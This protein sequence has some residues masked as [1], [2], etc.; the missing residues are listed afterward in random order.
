MRK[1]DTEIVSM[2]GN[3]A[4]AMVK[5]WH[6]AVH[7]PHGWSNR[8]P[9]RNEN[10][11]S[12]RCLIRVISLAT[13]SQFALVP[14]AKRIFH[15]ITKQQS[16]RDIINHNH[17]LEPVLERFDLR[18]SSSQDGLDRSSHG[19]GQDLDFLIDMLKVFDAEDTFDVSILQAYP[20]PVIL[21]YLYRTHDFYRQQRLGEIEQSIEALL[22]HCAQEKPLL[23]LLR[24]AFEQYERYLLAHMNEEEAVLFPYLSYLH[25]AYTYGRYY[26]SRAFPQAPECDLV[27]FDHDH[28]TQDPARTFDVL[29][30]TIIRDHPETKSMMAFQILQTQL[31]QF[32]QDLRIHE[33]VENHVLLPKARQMQVQVG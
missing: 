17:Q 3:D 5:A 10:S 26:A 11:H 7:K 25:H 31:Q 21:D 13:M 16:I 22:R 28:D 9:G 24:P 4:V 8:H 20:L 33:A 19:K 2:N 12:L 6:S 23:M 15:M 27:T 18:Y 30:E 29:L 14:S 32:R 1:K